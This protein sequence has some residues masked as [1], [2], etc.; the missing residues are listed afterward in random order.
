MKYTQTIFITLFVLLMLI[1][2]GELGYLVYFKTQNRDYREKA[3]E[4]LISEPNP[5]FIKKEESKAAKCPAGFILVPGDSSYKTVDF[6]VMK[7]EAKCD[8]NGD[9]FGDSPSKG[10]SWN[11]L[12]KPCPKIVSSA[13]GLPITNISLTDSISKLKNDES[14]EASAKKYCEGSGWHLLTNDEYMTIAKNIVESDK[15]WCNPQVPDKCGLEIGKGVVPSGH[16][17]DKPDKALPASIDDNDSC[18]LTG[19]ATDGCRS[20]GAQKRTFV[21]KN[22]EIIWDIVGNVWEMVDLVINVENQPSAKNAFELRTGWGWSEFYPTDDPN[23]WFLFDYGSLK[24][25]DLTVSGTNWTSALGI[26]KISHNSRPNVT[27]KVALIRGG[28]WTSISNAGI[29]TTALIMGPYDNLLNINN[30]TGFRC[31]VKPS[32]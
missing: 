14:T 28:S 11:N 1:T 26:G 22:N 16:S 7:Y 15:N 17:N 10:E 27:G 4:I 29:F 3:D 9:G 6:C 20:N 21:L 12:K 31:A 2:V 24:P 13:E 23:E 8:F 30:T 19:D 18:Y 25:S 32:I 5:S